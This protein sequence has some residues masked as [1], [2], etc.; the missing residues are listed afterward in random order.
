AAGIDWRAGDEVII[1]DLEHVSG[2]APWQRLATARGVKIINLKSLGGYVSPRQIE[3]AIT[4]STRLVCL[5]HVSYA[6]GAELPVREACAAA[7]RRGVMV[8]V[9]GAQSAGHILVDVRSIGCDFYAL[10]GQKWLLGPEG[11]GALYVRK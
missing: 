2:V 3:E 6:T 4:D 7:S 11:T 9:D 8:V 10:P 5:S 1:S